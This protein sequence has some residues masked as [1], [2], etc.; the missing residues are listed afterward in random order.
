M[1]T[2]IVSLDGKDRTIAIPTGRVLAIEFGDKPFVKV[3][4]ERVDHAFEV[5][6]K[7]VES[8][9]QAYHEAIKELWS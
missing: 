1:R 3:W 6:F 2:G 8:A 9:S 5:E 7:D 4:V